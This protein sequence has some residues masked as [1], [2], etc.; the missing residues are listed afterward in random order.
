MVG[1]QLD[2][3]WFDGSYQDMALAIS[4]ARPKQH[5]FSRCLDLESLVAQIKKSGNR[6]S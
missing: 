2:C 5:G 6:R 4:Q 3:C 1:L